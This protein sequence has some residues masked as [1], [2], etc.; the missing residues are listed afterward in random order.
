MD[1]EVG[2]EEVVDEE[3]GGEEEVSTLWDEQDVEMLNTHLNYHSEMVTV[4]QS[5]ISGGPDGATYIPKRPAGNLNHLLFA[6]RP[7]KSAK[8]IGSGLQA[9]LVSHICNEEITGDIDQMS[10]EISKA[11][12]LGSITDHLITGFKLLKH[13]HVKTL[14]LSIRYGTWL[15]SA[16]ELFDLDKQSG[17]IKNITWAKWLVENVGIKDSYGRKLRDIAKLLGQYPHFHKLGLSFSEVY[18]R[19]NEIKLALSCYPDIAAY[20]KLP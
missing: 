12:S 15:N 16:F 9:Y 1:E 17:K 20:W 11:T 5:L 7:A 2:D 13:Q 10:T 6:F 4:I 8:L 14:S 18:Q 19:R 3:A